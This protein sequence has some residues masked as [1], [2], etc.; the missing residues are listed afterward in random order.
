M[1][2]MTTDNDVNSPYRYALIK[3]FFFPSGVCEVS[4]FQTGQ[5]SLIAASAHIKQPDKAILQKM[6]SLL[7]TP[8]IETKTDPKSKKRTVPE[9][10]IARAESVLTV[11]PMKTVRSLLVGDS[12]VEWYSRI[13]DPDGGLE[14]DI[15]GAG[16]VTYATRKSDVRTSLH[17]FID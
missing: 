4:S 12:T 6:S 1:T 7:V 13:L 11:I 9:P 15:V 16:I 3:E 5:R 14:G 8:S 10:L 17:Y 2:M